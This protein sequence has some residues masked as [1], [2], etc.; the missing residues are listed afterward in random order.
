MLYSTI[1]ATQSNTEVQR[2]KCSHTAV[3][4]DYIVQQD[5]SLYVGVY[6][7]CSSDEATE[8]WSLSLLVW[9]LPGTLQQLPKW[10]VLGKGR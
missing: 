8:I 3:T 4:Q 7:V 9:L 2:S 1:L 6:L 5:I 10:C